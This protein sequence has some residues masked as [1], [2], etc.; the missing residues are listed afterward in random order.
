[1]GDVKWLHLPL[2]AP[3]ILSA[4]CDPDS[5][6]GDDTACIL[7]SEE[8]PS[9]EVWLLPTTT[10]AQRLD[11]AIKTRNQGTVNLLL[12]KYDKQSAPAGSTCKRLETRGKF[13]KVRVLETDLL[14]WVPLHQLRGTSD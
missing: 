4:A 1:M 9:D 12:A 10:E 14:G 5:E 11:G 6:L 7:G 3:L 13:A 8:D 2:C